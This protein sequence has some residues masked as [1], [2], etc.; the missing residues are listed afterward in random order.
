MSRDLFVNG[1]TMVYVKGRAD[2]G[3]GA[4]QQLGLAE[5]P[6]KVSLDFKHKDVNLDAWGGEVPAEVQFMLASASVSMSLIHF[7][8]SILDV[9]LMES[10]A[11]AP[12]IG[13]L[14][15]AGSR[16]GNNLPRFAGGG[17][18]GNHYIGLN[19]SSPIGNKPWRFFYSY[20]TGPPIDFPLGTEKSVVGVNW[21]VI[22]YI[23][24]PWNGGLGADG[25]IL[26]D[27]ILDS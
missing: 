15:R 13:Q 6:I 12:A 8:R 18:L 24:D 3:I 23:Q 2:S 7:D 10:M 16:M 21:R 19:L 14:R 11:G 4:I 26:W 25:A 17:E 9:C 27:H 5:G 1:E 20:M 22:P